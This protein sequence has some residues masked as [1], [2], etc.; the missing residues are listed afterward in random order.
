MSLN[1]L[2]TI[3][4]AYVQ[5]VISYGIIFGGNSLLSANILRLKKE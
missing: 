2:R 4:F 5:S 3:Y 1:V